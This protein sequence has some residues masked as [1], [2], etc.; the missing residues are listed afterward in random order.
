VVT[1]QK[2]A[3]TLLLDGVTLVLTTVIGMMV[4]AFYHPFLL[5][6]DVILL[7][8]IAFTVFVLGRGAVKT[9]VKESKAKYAVAAWL[10][11]LAR[12][13]TAFKLHSGA[14]FALDRADQLAV[15]W[16]DS[17][18][19]HFRIL[20]RQILFALSL[21]AVAATVLLGLGGWLVITRELTLG[22]LVAAELIVMMIVGSFAKLGKYLESFYDLLASVDKVGRLFDLNTE[23]HNKLYHLRDTDA[24]EVNMRDVSFHYPSGTILSNFD[25]HLKPHETVALTGPSGSGKSTVVDLLCGLRA[26]DSGHIELDGIDLRELRPDSLREHLAAARSV[27][28]FDGTIDENVHLNRPEISPL[29]VREALS[30][31]GLLDEM[32]WLADGLETRLLTHGSPLSSG[33]ALRLMIARAIVGRPRLLLIDGTLDGLDDDSLTTVLERLTSNDAPWTLLI[34]TGRKTVID[35]CQRVVSLGLPA[36]NSAN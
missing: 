12:H 26:P 34:A 14:Q 3:A 24:A 32:L 4:L 9:A 17:R 2:A 19:K 21:Q 16:L 31:V 7:A 11:E 15:T 35:A 25:L 27:E 5:G 30:T 18:K 23:P 13:H 29:D 20:M 22:Q 28:I 1:I 33:Q 6:F 8:L 10:E 36:M